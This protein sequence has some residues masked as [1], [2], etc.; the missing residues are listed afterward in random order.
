MLRQFIKAAIGPYVHVGMMVLMMAVAAQQL[1]LPQL[2]LETSAIVANQQVRNVG[3]FVTVCMVEIESS[4]IAHIATAHT[5]SAEQPHRPR[6]HSA[7]ARITTVDSASNSPRT[8]SYRYSAWI[9]KRNALQTMRTMREI[10]PFSI[11]DNTRRHD[12]PALRAPFDA[13]LPQRLTRQ[14][15]FPLAIHVPAY[16]IDFDGPRNDVTTILACS[17]GTHDR[18]LV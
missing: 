7:S 13:V 10:A 15:T 11:D 16:S 4:Q 2:V 6:L 14:T 9:S 1:A 17:R 5:T 18:S 3:L 8:P 12:V